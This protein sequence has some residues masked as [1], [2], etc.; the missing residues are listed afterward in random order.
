MSPPPTRLQEKKERKPS[1]PSGHHAGSLRVFACWL[2]KRCHYAAGCLVMRSQSK[3]TNSA[4]TLIQTQRRAFQIIYVKYTFNAA[5]PDTVLCREWQLVNSTKQ[6]SMRRNHYI[7]LSLK[8]WTWIGCFLRLTFQ[9][10]HPAFIV[11][12]AEYH[13]PS[14][15]FPSQYELSHIHI[16]S[17]VSCISVCKILFL[18]ALACHLMRPA[19]I[20]W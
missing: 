17:S 5:W 1:N 20:A 15:D 3:R 10:V 8:T 7:I 14:I 2:T 11:I 6:S 18:C 4:F 9:S 19:V 12:E 13:P 16:G